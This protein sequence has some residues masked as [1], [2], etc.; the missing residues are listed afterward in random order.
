MKWQNMA[1]MAKTPKKV[2]FQFLPH[3]DKD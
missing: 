2:F 1:K 3:K